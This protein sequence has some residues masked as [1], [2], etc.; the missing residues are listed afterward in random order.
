MTTATIDFDELVRDH[1]RRMVN[2][3]FAR[4]ENWHDAEDAVQDALVKAW[5]QR[6]SYQPRDDKPPL[7]WVIT[8][9]KY[10][11]L[12]IMHHRRRY[13]AAGE[14]AGRFAEQQEECDNSTGSLCLGD[15][16]VCAKVYTALVPLPDQQRL[17]I[18]MHCLQGLDRKVVT[19]CMRVSD[20]EFYSL[21][22]RGIEKLERAQD[23]GR[24]CHKVRV[25][26]GGWLDPELAKL[27]S[28]TDLLDQLA[29]R[30]RQVLEL[31]YVRGYS[32]A[33]TARRAGISVHTVQGATRDGLA[34]L[35]RL[36]AGGTPR[37]RGIPPSPAVAELLQRPDLADLLGRLAPRQRQAFQYRHVDGLG[38]VKTAE[39]MHASLDAVSALTQNAVKGAVAEARKADARTAVES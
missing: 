16:E 21:I 33:E 29:P 13:I 8:I 19:G 28:R 2:A 24:V 1:R 15:P 18:Q 27:C 14:W 34:Q 32:R 10:Q 9:A 11:A 25:S 17:A 23:G 35:R 22:S 20:P 37:R 31:R 7:A 4:T 39:L 26:A 36:A 3:T 30:Q 38:T 12:D 6:D 5:E